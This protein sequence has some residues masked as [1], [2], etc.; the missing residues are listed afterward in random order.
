LLQAP[1]P[2]VSL[3]IRKPQRCQP[4][5]PPRLPPRPV[6]CGGPTASI[7]LRGSLAGSAQPMVV[8]PLSDGLRVGAQLAGDPRQRPC[9]LDYPVGQVGVE[10]GK[11]EL[12]GALGEALLGGTALV[13]AAV[14]M[15]NV[16]ERLW[17]GPGRSR[18]GCRGAAGC[19]IP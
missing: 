5:R 16:D 11:A 7:L 3:Q 4:G 2:Q 17:P 19:T 12:G 13:G 15:G 9:L 18:S 8:Q 6:V 1:H 14:R 10:A